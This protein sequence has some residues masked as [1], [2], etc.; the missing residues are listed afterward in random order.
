VAAHLT[1][2]R[3]RLDRVLYRPVQVRFFQ[4]SDSG[5]RAL[6]RNFLHVLPSVTP[7]LICIRDV[8]ERRSLLKSLHAFECC[9]R[10]ALPRRL[11]SRLRVGMR[12]LC[13][14]AAA[15]V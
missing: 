12:I 13:V 3:R 6:L 1:L 14:R 8:A 4:R 11:S 15:S 5:C 10:C 7:L 9:C 2:R